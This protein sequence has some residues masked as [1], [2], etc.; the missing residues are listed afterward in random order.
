MDVD[1]ATANRVVEL[2]STAAPAGPTNPYGGA[3][4][5][6]ETPLRTERDAERK[7]NL[8]S[9]RRWV[10]ENL[11]A[12]NVLGHPTGYALL[13]GENAEP[14]AAPD[15]WVRKRAGFLNNHIW[16]TPY[17][18]SE[19]YAG[20]DYPNQSRGGDGLV[21]WTTANRSIDNQDIVLW[22]TMGI[23]HN[24]RPEDWPVMPVHAAGFLLV[25]WGFFS[26][27]PTMDLPPDEVGTGGGGPVRLVH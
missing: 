13:P 4:F 26:H 24:P 6:K 25:P 17:D 14:F 21:K 12:K 16:V 18:P 3:F 23:T 22:Y 10:V 27:N 5:M 9:S 11:S 7:L 15:S 8:A 20:G 1:G 2:N 19:M